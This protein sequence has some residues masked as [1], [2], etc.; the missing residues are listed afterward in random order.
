MTIDKFSAS[1]E[2]KSLVI[3]LTVDDI[4]KNMEE[5][6]NKG[7]VQIDEDLNIYEYIKEWENKIFN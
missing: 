7:I 5:L 4:K 1:G 2:T 6:S 3:D